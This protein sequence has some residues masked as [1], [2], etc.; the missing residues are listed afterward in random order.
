MASFSS[1]ILTDLF[2]IYYTF[3]GFQKHSFVWLWLWIHQSLS[4]DQQSIDLIVTDNVTLIKKERNVQKKRDLFF[5]YLC[6]RHE[7]SLSFKNVM[8][9]LSKKLLLP[10]CWSKEHALLTRTKIMN[11]WVWD[12]REFSLHSTQLFLLFLCVIIWLRLCVF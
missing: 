11:E 12:M 7:L 2:Y 8:V 6:P 5:T 10:F 9:W 1:L 3:F 4:V